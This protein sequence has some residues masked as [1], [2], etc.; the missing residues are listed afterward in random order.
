MKILSLKEISDHRFDDYLT[1][2][3]RLTGNADWIA[4]P[5]NEED[6]REALGFVRDRGVTVTISGARTGIAGGAVPEGGLLLSLEKINRILE[7]GKE[8]EGDYYAIV[9]PGLL[10]VDLKE[11]LSDESLFYPPDPTEKTASIGGT[12]A[13]DASGSL[14]FG[15]GSTRKYIRGLRIMLSSGDIMD[16]KRGQ[17]CANEEGIIRFFLNGKALSFQRPRYPWPEIKNV[18]GYFTRPGMD[19]MDL[20]IG[21]EGSLGIITRIELKLLP[22]PPL[23]AGIML[24]L[25][26]LEKALGVV[27]VCRNHP[28]FRP[29]AMEYFGH[30]SVELLSEAREEA[31]ESSEIPAIPEKAKVIV[32][33]EKLFYDED[34]MDN[35]ILHLEE[36]MNRFELSP[37]DTWAELDPSGVSKMHDFRHALPETLNTIVGRIKTEHPSI[38]KLGTDFAVPR[39][40]LSDLLNLYEEHYSRYGLAWVSFGHIGDNHVHSNVIPRNEEEYENGNRAIR[41][42]ALKVVKMGGTVSAEHGTG[43]LK[44]HLLEIMIGENGMNE[45]MRV[46]RIF[47]PGLILS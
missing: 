17:Y 10:L 32:Y 19:L 45:M 8:D 27:N 4:F 36:V 15:Y 46:K 12:V 42:I 13:C 5:E 1:D 24:Y 33:L 22:A 35:F 25:P 34:A 41:E 6:V 23:V 14:S 29:D 44:K 20:F 2:E 21:S 39:E 9:E 18:A 30:R 7:I 40:K 3:S 16:L 11:R 37:D 38:T 43:K 28:E 31:G 26:S 47:D